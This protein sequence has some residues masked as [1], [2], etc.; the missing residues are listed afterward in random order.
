MRYHF[1]IKHEH[2]IQITVKKA[3]KSMQESWRDR[4]EI[5]CTK[6]GLTMNLTLLWVVGAIAKIAPF[7]IWAFGKLLSGTGKAVR[8]SLKAS[9]RAT[10]LSAMH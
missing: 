9:A 3:Y 2:G 10:D 7:K 5:E 1:V 8:Q 4:P 6:L